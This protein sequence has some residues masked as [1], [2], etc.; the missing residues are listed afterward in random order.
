[1]TETNNSPTKPQACES[2]SRL[3]SRNEQLTKE[4]N[5]YAEVISYISEI[6]NGTPECHY[7][8]IADDVRLMRERLA[9]RV[10]ELEKGLQEIVDDGCEGCYTVAKRVLAKHSGSLNSADSASVSTSTH[11]AKEIR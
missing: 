2:C 10:E 3:A 4:A 5:S 8:V 7:L 9:S 1:M 11:A 6:V